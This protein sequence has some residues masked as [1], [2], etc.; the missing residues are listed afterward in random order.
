MSYQTETRR[1]TRLPN[2]TLMTIPQR[3]K[4]QPMCHSGFL[5]FLEAALWNLG[6]FALPF[7][8]N[9]FKLKLN[10]RVPM[11]LDKSG[12]PCIKVPRHPQISLVEG[13]PL[14]SRLSLGARK[15]SRLKLLG[16]VIGGCILALSMQHSVSAQMLQGAESAVQTLFSGFLPSGA[17]NIVQVIFGIARVIFFGLLF[18][19]IAFAANESRRGG[20]MDV[21]FAAGSVLVIGIV[22]MQAASQIV[23]GGGG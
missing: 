19:V 7:Y 13:C 8:S 4:R 16:I 22:L 20:S 9:T 3:R 10:S 17:A 5:S 1:S 2:T 15:Y 11:T 21:W 23:F 12:Q 18:V 14:L 6:K